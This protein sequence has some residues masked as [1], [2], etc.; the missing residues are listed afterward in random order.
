[1]A[2]VDRADAS[3]SQASLEGIARHGGCVVICGRDHLPSAMVLPMT[4]H[5]DI[6]DRLRS[7]IA[8]GEPLRKR[9]WAR[10]VSAK[11]NAQ[12]TV[13]ELA[14]QRAAS[15]IRGLASRVRSGDPE[16]VESQ[17]ARIF[18]RSW[19]LPDAEAAAEF[20]RRPAREGGG[21]P[22]ALLD[23]GYAV[24]RAAI[25]RCLVASGLSPAL[26]IGHSSRRNPFNLADDL[27]EPLRPLVDRRVRDLHTAGRRAVGRDSK[28]TLL[29]VLSE[30]VQLPAEARPVTSP[31]DV[32]IGAYVDSFVRALQRRCADSADLLRIPSMLKNPV[33]CQT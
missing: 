29:G 8:L 20:R 30:S 26:G 18:W 24:L 22:N 9:L 13:A 31:L 14:D 32:A 21:P 11:L 1:M 17:A 6:G 10:L 19:L 5:S 25:A 28:P 3:F 23:Y 12:A 33:S 7:Q 4:L 16:N 15:R 27:L 2:I